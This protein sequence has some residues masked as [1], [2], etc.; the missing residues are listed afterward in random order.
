MTRHTPKIHVTAD[1]PVDL[2]EQVDERV[3]KLG[4]TRSFAVRKGLALFLQTFRQELT[5]IVI[6]PAPSVA[7][8]EARS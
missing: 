7:E 1:V 4:V 8:S 5:E 6:E 3:D 2:V